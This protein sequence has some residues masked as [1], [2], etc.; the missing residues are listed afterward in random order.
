MVVSFLAIG[1]SVKNP[2][3]DPTK[4]SSFCWNLIKCCFSFL[5]SKHVANVAAPTTKFKFDIGVPH[6]DFHKHLRVMGYFAL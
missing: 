2:P 6:K 4:N 5:K 1:S 3:L